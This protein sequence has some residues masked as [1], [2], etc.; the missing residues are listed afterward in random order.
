[1]GL[2]Q[3]N[4]L[5]SLLSLLAVSQLFEFLYFP[6]IS[7]R[8]FYIHLYFGCTSDQTVLYRFRCNPQELKRVCSSL[9][10]A[11]LLDMSLG[12]GVIVRWN[13]QN[14]KNSLVCSHKMLDGSV[15][16]SNELYL[17][18]KHKNAFAVLKTIELNLSFELTI[19]C[20]PKVL[21][22]LH[23]IYAAISCAIHTN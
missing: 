15:V 14:N 6:R 16:G 20:P 21:A 10:R 22:G 23:I 9:R 4:F 19:Q 8:I 13:N 18:E 17:Q 3:G 5:D 1:V 11:P 2:R 12:P 7:F